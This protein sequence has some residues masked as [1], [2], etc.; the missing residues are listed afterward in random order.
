MKLKKDFDLEKYIG[1]Y[2]NYWIM[3]LLILM[4]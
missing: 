1:E 2:N 4:I 3:Y